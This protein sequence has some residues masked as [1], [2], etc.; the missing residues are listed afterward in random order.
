MMSLIFIALAGMILIGGVL[1]LVA[2][3]L[4][5]KDRDKR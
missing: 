4:D 2:Q 1:F 3:I 5:K